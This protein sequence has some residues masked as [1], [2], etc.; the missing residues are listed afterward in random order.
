MKITGE[1]LKKLGDERNLG[2]SGVFYKNT[3]SVFCALES[4]LK[5]WFFLSSEHD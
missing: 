2:A 5:S 1:D 4:Q 3:A